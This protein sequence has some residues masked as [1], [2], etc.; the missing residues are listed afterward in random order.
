MVMAV[1]TCLSNPSILKMDAEISSE[2]PLNTDYSAVKTCLSNPSILQM[3]AE[4]SSET[5][6]NFSDYTASH[7]IN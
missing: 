7:P 4:I 1:K 6:M 5:P 2:T 3:D